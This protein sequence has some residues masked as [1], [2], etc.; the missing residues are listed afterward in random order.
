MNATE[1][2][3]GDLVM[4]S[5]KPMHVTFAMMHAGIEVKPIPLTP[6]ILEK[7]GFEMHLCDADDVNRRYYE[8]ADW[9]IG[10]CIDIY[11]LPNGD[12]Y[13]EID[14]RMDRHMTQTRIYRVISSVHELQHGI[15]YG[16]IEKEVVV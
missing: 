2:M 15:K 4:V 13:M 16:E 14:S 8:C 9:N 7:N 11:P 10:W 3:L 5:G 12:Y 6:E 1:L